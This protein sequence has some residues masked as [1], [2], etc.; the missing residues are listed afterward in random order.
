M[1]SEMCIRDRGISAIQSVTCPGGLLSPQI[2][3]V[4]DTLIWVQLRCLNPGREASC[5]DDSKRSFVYSVELRRVCGR[6]FLLDLLS[7]TQFTKCVLCELPPVIAA[8]YFGF[9][10]G[11]FCEA[12]RE[13]SFCLILRAEK[14]P[15]RERR[16]LSRTIIVYHFPP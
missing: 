4:R 15:L 10:W 11:D 2:A 1:G 6:P 13:V 9:S 16:E 7:V 14:T 12:L 8:D 5:F 3:T